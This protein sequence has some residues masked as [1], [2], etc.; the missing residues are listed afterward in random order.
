MLALEKQISC[1]LISRY[2]VVQQSNL[3]E[4]SDQRDA[5]DNE[6]LGAWMFFNLQ[7]FVHDRFEKLS[8]YNEVTTSQQVLSV[9]QNRLN[10]CFGLICFHTGF[11]RYNAAEKVLQ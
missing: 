8:Y 11:K 5:Q 7:D 10:D 3:G 2:C 6:V 1:K 4:I 9:R